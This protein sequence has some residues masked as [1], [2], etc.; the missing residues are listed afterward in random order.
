MSAGFVPY[1]LSVMVS[2]NNSY[3]VVLE[4]HLARRE[5]TCGGDNRVS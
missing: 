2:S 5:G 3:P 1:A 4:D